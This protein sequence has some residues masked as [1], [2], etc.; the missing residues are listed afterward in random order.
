MDFQEARIFREK[1]R[2][3]TALRTAKGLIDQCKLDKN[4]LGI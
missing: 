1:K 3:E 4:P 2:E